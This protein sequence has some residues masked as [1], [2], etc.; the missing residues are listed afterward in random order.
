MN[1]KQL[2]SALLSWYREALKGNPAPLEAIHNAIDT[3]YLFDMV[4]EEIENFSSYLLANLYEINV[5]DDNNPSAV[6][7]LQDDES[8]G[9]FI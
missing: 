2:R 1:E 7:M 3:L 8:G 5:L 4:S 9:D 6:F